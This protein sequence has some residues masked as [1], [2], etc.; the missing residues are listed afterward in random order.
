MVNIKVSVLEGG[1]VE[2]DDTFVVRRAICEWYRAAPE[3]RDEAIVSGSQQ[4]LQIFLG[5]GDFRIEERVTTSVLK[6]AKVSGLAKINKC[7]SER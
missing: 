2:T 7:S 5:L 6:E 1:D 3:D 4:A